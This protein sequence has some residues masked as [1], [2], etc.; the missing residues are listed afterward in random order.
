MFKRVRR[1]TIRWRRV[2]QFEPIRVEGT[3]L[4]RDEA[5]GRLSDTAEIHAGM[6]VTLARDPDHEQ[7]PKAVAVETLSN[8]PLGYL[9]AEVADWIAPLLDS[10]RATFDARIYALVD[11]DPQSNRGAQSFLLS[12]TQFEQVPV[13]QSSL[14]LALRALLRLPVRAT[15]WCVGHTAA[16]FHA[17]SR[18]RVP[19]PDRY[20]ADDSSGG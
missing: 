13:E 15:N 17:F 19:P 2:A 1:R 8:Q 6:R 5:A 20:A 7:D 16:I 12:L 9:P 4:A 10:G 3:Q 14:G 11:A 18:T